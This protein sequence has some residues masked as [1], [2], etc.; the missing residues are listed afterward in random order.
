[1]CYYYFTHCLLFLVNKLVKFE[2]FFFVVHKAEVMNEWLRNFET[3]FGWCR[4]IAV[5]M[6]NYETI[7]IGLDETLR[8]IES[9][10]CIF[11]DMKTK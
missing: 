3:F 11:F 10:E 9:P 6:R 1:M 4:T 2:C 7:L 8:S 5:N